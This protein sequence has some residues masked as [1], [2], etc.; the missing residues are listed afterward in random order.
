MSIMHRPL[1]ISENRTS[2]SFIRRQLY[3]INNQYIQI[4]GMTMSNQARADVIL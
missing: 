1:T 3:M 4:Y 2:N